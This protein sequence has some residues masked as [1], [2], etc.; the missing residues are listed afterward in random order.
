MFVTSKVLDSFA[1]QGILS[2]VQHDPELM[3]EA[4][5]IVVNG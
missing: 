5:G 4:K 1:Q 3:P 2:V